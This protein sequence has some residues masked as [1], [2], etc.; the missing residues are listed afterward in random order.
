M[1]TSHLEVQGLAH[2]MG[3]NAFLQFT[4]L[5]K[6][7]SLAP[8]V[9]AALMGSCGRASHE[10]FQMVWNVDVCMGPSLGWALQP[11]GWEIKEKLLIQLLW[12]SLTL[13]S[14]ILSWNFG[15]GKQCFA[16]GQTEHCIWARLRVCGV[17]M[18]CFLVQQGE[19]NK[20]FLSHSEMTLL[21]NWF[22]PWPCL[23]DPE[24]STIDLHS[25]ILK[26]MDGVEKTVRKEASFE[27]LVTQEYSA[28]LLNLSGDCH[29]HVA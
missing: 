25:P 26:C 24:Q 19:E 1:S 5:P 3:D 4:L 21:K 9:K 16:Q 29:L 14:L 12:R 13:W 18:V 15:K 28:A 22:S 6:E 20:V 2:A 27:C 10:G 23:Q 17:F 7:R 8:R 11:P